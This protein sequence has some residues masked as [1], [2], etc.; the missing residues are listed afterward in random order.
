MSKAEQETI[1]TF[2]PSDSK[3][4]IWSSDPNW[5]KKIEKL[6]GVKSDSHAEVD[7]PKGWITLKQ[8]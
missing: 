1:I 4:N 8:R 5:I 2:G 6:G 3:A 7:I